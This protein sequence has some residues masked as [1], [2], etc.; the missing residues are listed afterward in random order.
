MELLKQLLVRVVVV[1]LK[2]LLLIVTM[3]RFLQ[4]LIYLGGVLN[5]TGKTVVGTTS[6]L[7]GK[8]I[9]GNLR[10]YGDISMAES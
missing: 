8:E 10:I 6:N 9:Y 1:V 3:Y 5:V 2:L 4:I 7:P